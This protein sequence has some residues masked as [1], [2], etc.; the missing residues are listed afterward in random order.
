MVFHFECLSVDLSVCKK[1]STVSVSHINHTECT[2][3]INLNRRN[4]MA[5]VGYRSRSSSRAGGGVLR[6][7]GD[8]AHIRTPTRIPVRQSS[9]GGEVSQLQ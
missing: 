9:V 7:K 3:L 1:N 2:D 5:A 8:L 4:K 6:A